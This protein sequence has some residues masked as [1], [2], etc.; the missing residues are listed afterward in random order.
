MELDAKAWRSVKGGRSVYHFQKPHILQFQISNALRISRRV[1][2][3]NSR[4]GGQVNIQE[5]R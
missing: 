3:Q 5:M 1:G 2:L 4:G